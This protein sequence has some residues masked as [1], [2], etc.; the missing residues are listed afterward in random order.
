MTLDIQASGAPLELLANDA[1]QPENRFME[2]PVWKAALAGELPKPKLKKLLLAFYPALAGPGRFA[3]AAKVSQISP[4]DGKELFLQ[5]HES[6]KKP[7]ADADT[8]WRKVLL[9]LGATEREL[10]EALAQPSAEAADLVDVIRDHGLKS[11]AAE[12]SVLPGC[13]SATCRHSGAGS[14]TAW[15]STMASSGTRSATCATRHPP[16]QKIGG[17]TP[18][19]L[20]WAPPSPTGRVRG[21]P[22]GQGRGGAPSGG[23]GLRGWLIGKSDI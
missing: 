2:H 6:L 14:P 1:R 16:R 5:L 8:G 18:P 22:R 13:S 15:R 19:T 17:K 7:E 9:A 23:L 3:F 11:T 12:A 4:Q 10:N 21:R 20:L